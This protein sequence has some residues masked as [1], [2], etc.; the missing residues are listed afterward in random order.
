MGTVTIGTDTFDIYG[1]S[2]GLALRANGSS[3]YYALY[4][5][6]VAADADDVRRKHVE[7]TQLIALLPFDD[8]A[9]AVPATA[10]AAVADACYELVLAAIASAAVLTQDAAGSNVKRIEAKGVVVENFSPVAGGRFP[11]RVMALLAPLLDAS[12]ASGDSIGGGSFV[13][14]IDACSDFDDADRYTVSGA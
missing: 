1:T 14:G 6:A 12:T 3:T 2:A 7:A 8:P 4:T 10:V 9:N 11:A 13:A 5:D